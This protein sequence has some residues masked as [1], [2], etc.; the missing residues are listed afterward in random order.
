LRHINDYDVV[1]FDCD[2]VI[3]DSNELKLEAMSLAVAAVINDKKL[4][5]QCVDYFRNNFGKSRYH[6]IRHFVEHI[7]KCDDASAVYDNILVNYADRCFALYLQ[8]KEA[9]NFRLLI[10]KSK[11]IH[12][13]ASGS[14]QEELRKVFDFK[15]LTKLF[16]SIEGSPK[17]K[18]EIVKEIVAANFNSKILMIGDAESDFL[19]AQNNKIDF[20]FYEPLSTVKEKM[21]KL[22]M[23][24]KFLIIN[25]FSELLNDQS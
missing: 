13:V 12:Y 25:D 2:G 19:A 24:Y 14:D 23:K 1:I 8:A 18:S 10:S 9:K 5:L 4:I 3:L 22:S 16:K 6:H 15:G 7:I 17:N 20:I 11:C 21:V